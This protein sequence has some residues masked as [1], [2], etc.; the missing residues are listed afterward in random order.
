MSKSLSTTGA[1]RVKRPLSLRV[2]PS[3]M[4]PSKTW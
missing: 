4:F 1:N 3:L 2:W